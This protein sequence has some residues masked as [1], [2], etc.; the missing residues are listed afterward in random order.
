M[1]RGSKELPLYVSIAKEIRSRIASGVLQNGDK[2]PS[3]RELATEFDTTLMTVRKA[4]ELLEAEELVRTEHGVGM[5]A[6]APRV[7]EFE[8]ERIHGF[9]SEMEE[10]HQEVVT[11]LLAG[12]ERVVHGKAAAALAVEPLTALL[13]I[14][15]LRGLDGSPIVFQSSFLAPVVEAALEAFEASESLYGRIMART[16]IAVAMS[17]EVLVPIT[18]DGESAAILG[19]R[20]GEAA[21]RSTRLSRSG[22]GLPLVYDEAILAGDSFFLTAERAG[23]HHSYEFNFRKGGPGSLLDSCLGEE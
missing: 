18:L 12:P 8:R 21:M 6:S 20:P 2:L 1:P 23:K 5:F 19:R 13:S 15:R 14:R 3:Q 7:G 11:T 10:R 17:R 4:L 9:R 22:D 16:G